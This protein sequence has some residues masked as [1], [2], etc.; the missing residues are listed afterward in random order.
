MSEKKKNDA[1]T[2]VHLKSVRMAGFKNYL[3]PVELELGKVNFLL[4]PNGA[5]KSSFLQAIELMGI[6]SAPKVLDGLALE[7]LS[8]FGTLNHVSKG[9]V[10]GEVVLAVA[11]DGLPESVELEVRLKPRGN[12][13]Y[14]VREWTVS[15]EAS[16]LKLG[17]GADSKWY[18]SRVGKQR[19]AGLS[20]SA[21][22]LLDVLATFDGVQ[23][24]PGARDILCF[25]SFQ[26]TLEE[27]KR[28]YHDTG[29]RWPN[30]RVIA[31]SNELVL[32]LTEKAHLVLASKE[33]LSIHA[34][35]ETGMDDEGLANKS[36]P[37]VGLGNPE[38]WSQ[39]FN[40][41]SKEVDPT[42]ELVSLGLALH[43]YYMHLSSVDVL[44]LPTDYLGEASF[45]WQMAWLSWGQKSD[46]NG[47]DALD[48]WNGSNELLK[49]YD[50][51]SLSKDI[52]RDFPLGRRFWQGSKTAPKS[53]VFWLGHEGPFGLKMSDA[54]YQAGHGVSNEDTQ[55]FYDALD[56]EQSILDIPDGIVIEPTLGEFES[57]KLDLGPTAKRRACRGIKITHTLQKKVFEEVNTDTSVDDRIDARMHLG[58]GQAIQHWGVEVY[59]IGPDVEGDFKD[60]GSVFDGDLSNWST[61]D[62]EMVSCWI[63]QGPPFST[64]KAYQRA[65]AGFNTL[66][67]A[68]RRFGW[69]EVRYEWKDRRRV[70]LLRD[71]TETEGKIADTRTWFQEGNMTGLDDQGGFA[72]RNNEDWEQPMK[73]VP[74]PMRLQGR[75][76]RHVVA[77]ALHFIRI[78]CDGKSGAKVVAL[79]EPTAFLHPRLASEFTGLMRELAEVLGLTIIVETHNE[80]MI[81][82]LSTDRLNGDTLEDVRIHYV[83]AEGDD[84]VLPIRVDRDGVFTPA[85]PEGFLDKSSAMQREQR[86]LKK[87]RGA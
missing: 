47:F 36:R 62:S 21:Q 77:I 68:T 79:E 65:K 60:G 25:S 4:G 73:D 63:P 37:K 30:P 57:Y 6:L 50:E 26:E 19:L 86:Q 12:G 70:V 52:Y 14:Q 72:R 40:V 38:T 67:S 8:R 11:M 15:T 10:A 59:H 66:A 82:Q 85:I 45:P 76:V 44:S 17:R 18:M 7:D 31:V 54:M 35:I 48:G 81:R 83:G 2:D 16:V 39:F 75:G 24:E 87:K 42:P 9:N 69:G 34:W 5:G 28:G 51:G 20:R 32:C 46:A 78:A 3:H 71:S 49:E 33:A 80:Y 23:I 61:S 29:A 41:Q 64:Q 1:N 55:A 27:R 58:I 53:L 43:A 22:S 56:D 13:T 74:V 84:Y